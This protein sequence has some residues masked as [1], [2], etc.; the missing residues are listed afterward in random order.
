[1]NILGQKVVECLLSAGDNAIRLNLAKGLY[2]YEAIR[3]QEK[4]ATGK[5]VIE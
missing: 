3:N 4:T 2:Y 1:M 5:L